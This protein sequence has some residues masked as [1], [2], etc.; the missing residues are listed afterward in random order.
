MRNFFNRITGWA[1]IGFFTFLGMVFL[2]NAN[3]NAESFGVTLAPMNQSVVLMPGDTYNS[4]FVISNP[5]NSSGE[6][7]YELDVDSFYL[8]ND[9]N[10]IFGTNEDSNEMVNW[11]TFVSP[12]KGKLSPNETKEIE[13]T[14]NV[15]QTAPSG[16]QYASVVVIMKPNDTDGDASSDG[17]NA[18]QAAIKEI[19]RIGH[20][21]YAEIAGNTIK[22]GEIVDATVQ[23]FLFS[24]KIKGVS[25]IK[26]TGNVH[27][28][29]T[30]TMQIYPLFSSEEIFTNEEDPAHQIIFP[31]RT[32]YNELSWDDTP[33]IGIFNVVYTVEFED[34][35]AQVS[36]MVIIC[37]IWLLFIIIFAIVALIIWLVLRAKNRKGSRAKVEA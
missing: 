11:I 18:A 8:D 14:I 26:N 7:Y 20:L 28:K 15:P 13:F 4:S 6:T 30:Y 31:D 21:V 5:A 35:I 22:N 27:G 37:P 24:G 12:T 32:V 23:S 2:H 29:A 33:P 3:A 10:A 34:A 36:K 1:L 17:S 19:Q 25:S 9:S 16:G